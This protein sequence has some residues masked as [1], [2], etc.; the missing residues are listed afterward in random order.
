MPIVDALLPEFEHE[1]ANTRRYLERV[2]EAHFT[3]KPHPKS[4][5][6]GA[7]AQHLAEIPANVVRT[8]E[9]DAFEAG[10]P[11]GPPPRPAVGSRA[12]LL[13]IFERNVAAAK[14]KLQGAS[15]ED[16]MRA[17]TFSFKGHKVFTLPK[18]AALRAIVFNHTIHH[19]GQLGVY[20]RQ[21]DVPLPAIYGPTAD[22]PVS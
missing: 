10:A 1:M 2:P 19:R 8:M 6:L 21:R 15:D 22:E 5:S 14:G 12:E 20:L 11:G 9:T 17:W 18:A 4:R 13:E 16:M 7:L 3:W